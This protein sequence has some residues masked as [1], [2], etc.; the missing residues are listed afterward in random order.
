M[1]IFMTIYYTGM[2]LSVILLHVVGRLARPNPLA[3]F[4]WFGSLW[5]NLMKMEI[6]TVK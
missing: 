1:N 5:I 4:N 3:F 2:L 6:W